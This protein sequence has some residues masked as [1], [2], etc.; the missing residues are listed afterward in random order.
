MNKKGKQTRTVALA[1]L[2]CKVNQCETASFR[3]GFEEQGLTVVPFSQSA[4][5]YVINT[6]AVTARA[7]AQSRNL[8][9]RA[10]RCNPAARLVVTGCYAQVET[11]GILETAGNPVCIVGNSN[12]EKLVAAAVADQ[13]PDL[14]MIVDSISGQQEISRLP[15]RRFHDRTRAFLK[16]Q[17]G[18]NSF[19]SYCI[20]PYARGRSRSLLPAGAL[21]QA[22]VFVEE[23]CREI[24]LTGI[25]LGV[26]GLDLE[27]PSSL[28]ELAGELAVQNPAVRYRLSS[29]EPGEISGALLELI[30]GTANLMPHIHVPLQ[31]GDDRILQKMNRRYR[32]D[33]FRKIVDECIGRVPGMAIGV[34]V[35]VGFPGEDEQAFN[36]TFKLLAGLPVAYLHVFPFSRRPGTAAAAM[37]EQV[38]EKIKEER[39]ALLRELDNKKRIDFYKMHIGR[40]VRVLSEGGASRQRLHRGFSDNYIPVSFAAASELSNQLLDIRVERLAEKG[41]FGRIV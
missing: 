16:V 5:I 9:R 33:D 15:V 25:H 3:T 1:T 10:R 39:V 41:V 6:C 31:S 38:P 30:A 26:Y 27:P 37:S 8:I 20:V 36:N 14:E 19:C 24:V 12:K 28:L 2:G 35:L 34:D 4:D 40:T 17:D 7:A 29:L 22:R 32:A 13:G 11:E 18:C 23:G 21:K